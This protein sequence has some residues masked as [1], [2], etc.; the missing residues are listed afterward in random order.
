MTLR[1][2]AGAVQGRSWAAWWA[3]CGVAVEGRPDGSAELLVVVLV[4][5][6]VVSKRCIAG[7]A[8]ALSSRP[9]LLHF[10]AQG[11]ATAVRARLNDTTTSTFFMALANLAS[12]RHLSASVSMLQ[13]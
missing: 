10:V 2:M 9:S 5:K 6:S 12:C 13:S 11:M 4:Q 8:V 7:G 3:A 1:C